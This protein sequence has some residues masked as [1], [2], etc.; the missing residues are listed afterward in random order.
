M[1]LIFSI[2]THCTAPS[3]V[4]CDQHCLNTLAKFFSFCTHNLKHLS[5]SFFF[6]SRGSFVPIISHSIR[7]VKFCR[8]VHFSFFPLS[9]L[10]ILLWC[11]AGRAA[12]YPQTIAGIVF[13]VIVRDRYGVRKSHWVAFIYPPCFCDLSTM[14]LMVCAAMC[15]C[16]GICKTVQTFGVKDY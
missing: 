10:L 4:S 15:V 9:V 1:S 12:Y 6:Q 11:L 13:A 14:R 16:A 8:F 3:A 2:I 7:I 5:L